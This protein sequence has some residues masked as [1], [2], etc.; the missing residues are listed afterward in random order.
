MWNC[1]VK[2]EEE[3]VSMTS[4]YLTSLLISVESFPLVKISLKSRNEKGILEMTPAM[5]L[6]HWKGMQKAGHW[7]PITIRFLT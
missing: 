4:N 7:L 6:E 2:K 1:M 5:T 3:R